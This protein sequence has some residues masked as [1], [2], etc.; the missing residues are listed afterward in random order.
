MDAE[1][2]AA[3]RLFINIEKNFLT[4]NKILNNMIIMLVYIVLKMNEYEIKKYILHIPQ[5]NESQ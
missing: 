1:F 5:P 3:S 2:V 4:F